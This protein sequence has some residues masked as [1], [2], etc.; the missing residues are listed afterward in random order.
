MTYAPNWNIG[1]DLRTELEYRSRLP[2]RI[3]FR[4]D[5]FVLFLCRVSF[6][7]VCFV[8]FSFFLLCYR[9]CVVSLL[10]CFCVLFCLCSPGWLWIHFK[11]FVS[12]CLGVFVCFV[13]KFFVGVSV[14]FRMFVF[15]EFYHI[16]VIVLIRLVWVCFRLCFGT[17]LILVPILFFV[18]V[19]LFRSLFLFCFVLRFVF[20]IVF[21]I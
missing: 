13:L 6:S 14:H 2:L 4:V 15:S 18:H 3:A 9:V 19:C 11:C 16:C 1:Q 20:L 21:V 17:R 7:C 10:L 8:S 5:V 12:C